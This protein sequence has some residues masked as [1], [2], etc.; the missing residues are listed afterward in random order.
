M[1]TGSRVDFRHREIASKLHTVSPLDF[2]LTATE[3]EG[4]KPVVRPYRTGDGFLDITELSFDST[5][6]S[7][8]IVGSLFA[9][10][11]T[12]FEDATVI[13]FKFSHFFV[14]GEGCYDIVCQYNNLLWGRKLPKAVPP[15]GINNSLSKMITG[16]DTV[17]VDPPEAGGW[18]YIR[19]WCQFG[20]ADL[21]K[22]VAQGIYQN[23]AAKFGV[24]ELGVERHI[25]LPSKFIQELQDSCQKE[26]DQLRKG[27]GEGIIKLSKIDV[28]SAWWIKQ[29][30]YSSFRDSLFL[31]VGY[32]FNFSDRVEKD[33]TEKYF[34]GHYFGLYIPLGTVGE[35][36]AQSLA[37][38]A[39]KIRNHVAVAKQPSVIRDNLDYLESTQGRKILPLPKGGDSE[40]APLFSSWNKFPFEKLDFS[41]ALN[42]DTGLGTGKVL[43]NNPR[44]ALPLNI[45]WKPKLLFFN[46]VDGGV[47]CQS[48]QLP[49]H[50]KGFEDI[51]EYERPLA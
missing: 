47:W 29:R 33:P 48:M 31:S 6:R 34:Q 15:P 41:P 36:R 50:W 19:N 24:V 22:T 43:F 32:A 7:N 4:N 16:E 46:D 1:T 11:V 37:M 5:S 25:Y 9:I 26:I 10:R 3:R 12:L 38:I 51:N 40:G 21:F 23:Y 42:I 20:L 13:A 39:L 45:S 35:V 27:N 44:I 14:D 30:I 2:E 17:P 28:M 49:S 18:E 8:L